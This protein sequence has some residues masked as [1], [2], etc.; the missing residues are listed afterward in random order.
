MN[1]HVTNSV[2]LRDLSRSFKG[3]SVLDRISLDVP[4]GQFVSLLGESGSGK[5]TLLGALAGLDD[6]AETSGRYTTPKSVSVLFQDARLLPWKTVIENL[7]LGLREPNARDVAAAMLHE[8]GLGDK[9]DAWPATLS[10]GQKQRASLAR[11]LL[12]APDLLLA[13]EPFGALDA[14]TKLRMQA[15]LMKLVERTRPTV[16]LVTHDVD[17]ALRLSDRVLVLK[18]GRIAED[19]AIS[20]PHP[21]HDHQ[22]EII[23]LRARLLKSLGVDTDTI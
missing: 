9:A 6:D 12:R 17:E 18:N 3:K 7:T 2:V 14:L 1:V 11:S 8:V 15:L 19:H 20:L 4:R 22:A 10:G 5:T 16:I 23:S 21:R 13:D